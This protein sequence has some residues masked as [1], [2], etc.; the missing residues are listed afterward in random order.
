MSTIRIQTIR[1]PDCT[2]G[3]LTVGD[4]RC[5][6]LELADRGN[7]NGIS[8]IPAGTYSYFKRVS[9]SN[10]NVLELRGVPNRTNIQIHKGN[11]THNVK[12]CILVGKTIADIDSDGIPDV[13]ASGV[14][15]NEL[16]S[17]VDAEGT[18]TIERL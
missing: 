16:L 17:L 1:Q 15:L 5:F 2:V 18:V 3:V 7:A 9:P 4:F 13:T 6:T 8:C 14:T 10:G 11:Y 12:G